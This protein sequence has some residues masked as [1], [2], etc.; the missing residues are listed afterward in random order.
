VTPPAPA[1]AAAPDPCRH[2]G[3]PLPSGRSD[4]FCCPGCTLAYQL[5]QQS[6]LGAFYQRLTLSAGQRRLQPEIREHRHLG[7]SVIAEGKD[8]CGLSLMVDGLHC[9]ACV[10]LIERVLAQQPEMLAARVNFS[11]GRLRLCWQGTP[12]RADSLVGL[13]E[14]LGFRLVPFDPAKLRDA[15][16]EV[17]SELMRCLAVAGFA[18]GNVMLLSVSVWA[19]HAG[20]MGAATRDLLHW[21]SALI[22]MP[23]ILY[24][25][26]PFFRSAWRALAH[27]RSNMDVPISVGVLL[28][29]A[30][31]LSET[32]RHGPYAYFDSAV[33]LLFFLLIG[34]VLD[35]RA[36]GRTRAVAAHLLSLGAAGATRLTGLGQAETVPVGALKAGDHL[37]VAAGEKLPA[38]GD[39][40]QG[41]SDVDGSPVTGESIPLAAAPGSHL[42]AGMVNLTAP[43]T[44][45]VGAAGDDTLL[46]E[47]LRLMEAAESG[48]ARYRQ[49]ADRLTRLYSPLVHSAALMTFG[50]WLV[51]GEVAWQVALLRAV[52]VLIVTCPCA[53]GLAIPAVQVV[54]SARLLKRGILLKSA[55]ALERL[56]DIDQVVFDKT[57]T[58]TTGQPRLLTEPKPD[59]ANLCLAAGLARSSRH[60]LA[61]ALAQACRL[62]PV[63]TD[64]EEIPGCGLLAGGT[65]L[66]SR[67]W[68]GLPED[69]R[70]DAELWLA[71][72]GQTPRRFAFGEDLRPDAAGVV[73]RLAGNGTG[74]A[75]LSGDRPAAVAIAAQACGIQDWQGGLDPTAKLRRVA[76]LQRQGRIVLM[77]GDGLN[78]AAALAAADVSM[79][80]A[81]AT[82]IAQTAADVVFQGARLA[83]VADL[84]DI[85]RQ[86]RRVVRQNLA[87]ALGYNL[88][89]VPLAVTGIVS[90]PIAAALMSSSSIIVVLNALR[91][92]RPYQE[93][94]L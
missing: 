41:N 53:M 36:R 83:P 35:H 72:A 21:L 27:R 17:G 76:A 69:G 19:G 60:P 74:V 78:D 28:T 51:L 11:T 9:P 3:L 34:R 64:V 92:M 32:V 10:W 61:R 50:Y 81:S 94:A 90:P 40:V 85:A 26:R 8:R 54:V 93:G 91:L 20:S 52:A 6:G 48:R 31:S 24:A 88:V 82:D 12:E 23:A 80:P 42:F 56:A 25:G 33:T 58:L 5:I 75:L 57:G 55:T 13:V 1:K 62:A 37:L 73:A 44:L 18:T 29:T 45:C 16:D 68:L 4:G 15:T 66:G 30:M 47:M 65:R 71:V 38:D 43:L 49:L 70:T 39:V 22:A 14:S 59:A 46:A 79:S 87:L 84:L 2:C 7:L 86:A 67:A 77:V 63:I 89:A